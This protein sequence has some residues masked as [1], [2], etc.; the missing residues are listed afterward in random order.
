MKRKIIFQLMFIVAVATL[1]WG[2]ASV[3]AAAQACVTIYPNGKVSD[4]PRWT[5]RNN[6]TFAVWHEVCWG[7][8]GCMADVMRP[9]SSGSYLDMNQTNSEAEGSYCPLSEWQEGKCRFPRIRSTIAATPPA[10]KTSP[11]PETP[12]TPPTSTD[13]QC[14]SGCVRSLGR[15]WC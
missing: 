4:F 15:C 11:L 7:G 2:F 6:C 14:G 3:P 13:N 8:R 12:Q 10:P 1:G 9:G 5:A